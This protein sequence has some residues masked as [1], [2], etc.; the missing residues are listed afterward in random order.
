M[1]LA[2]LFPCIT[3]S[4]CWAP[5]LDWL[6][7]DNKI[8]V[9]TTASERIVNQFLNVLPSCYYNQVLC[10]LNSG[11]SLIGFKV[12]ILCFNVLQDG[13]LTEISNY[14]ENAVQNGTYIAKSINDLEE[15]LVMC[16]DVN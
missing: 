16:Y 9:I 15:V 11:A 8:L 5:L 2:G 13:I 14:C 4:C 6:K 3:E 1:F 12:F 10:A 7:L